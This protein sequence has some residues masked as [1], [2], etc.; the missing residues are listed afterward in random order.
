MKILLIMNPAS[1]SGKGRRL[2]S[3]WRAD[4]REAGLAFDCVQTRYRGHGTELAMNASDYDT[5][6]AVGGDGT[7]NETLDGVLQSERT[8]LRM[9]ILYSG[10]SPDF[11]KFHGIPVRRPE[12]VKALVAAHSRKVDTVRIE[13]TGPDGK[14]ERAHFG[15]SSNIGLG[16]L[17]ARISNRIRRVAGDTAGTCAAA[18]YSIIVVPPADLEMRLDGSLYRLESV[19][20][21]SILKSPFIASGLKLNLDLRPDDGKLVVFAVHGKSRW[22]ILSMLRGFYSGKAA[23][24]EDVFVRECSHINVKCAEKAEIEFD[25]DPRGFLPIDIQI[26]PGS[27]NLVGAGTCNERI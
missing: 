2:W 24:R 21:L 17:I 6:V 12:A 23:S 1:R 26:I 13:F 15:C 5:V 22:K 16:A 19:N 18:I 25:G 3:R 11:C 20:N 14:R 10:T 7:I 27:L 9:G 4:L 8:D